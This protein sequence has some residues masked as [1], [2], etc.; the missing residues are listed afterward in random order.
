MLSVLAVHD[1]SISV[2]EIGFATR[3]VGTDGGV[4]SAVA[5]GAEQLALPPPFEPRHDQVQGPE[6]ETA[7]A[8]PAVQR[9]AVGA[10]DTGVPFAEPHTPFTGGGGGSGPL[11]FRVP[12]S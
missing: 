1:R 3:P 9:F 11:S 12:A 8:V 7:V 4:V 5:T 10:W 2:E 6:P